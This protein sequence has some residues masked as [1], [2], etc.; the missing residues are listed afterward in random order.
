MLSYFSGCTDPA[1]LTL[2]QDVHP[3]TTDY[4]VAE[5]LDY[6]N[7]SLNIWYCRPG[8]EYGST[9]VLIDTFEVDVNGSNEI[10]EA[11]LEDLALEIATAA[12]DFFYARGATSKAPFMFDISQAGFISAGSVPMEMVFYMEEGEASDESDEYPYDGTWPYGNG[13]SIGCPSTPSGVDAADL[14]RRDLRRSI[15]YGG[16][17]GN[18]GYAYNR[19]YSICF[20]VGGDNCFSYEIP[21]N[22]PFPDEL[23]DEEDLDNQNDVT[24]GDNFYDYLIFFNTSWLSNFH[25]CLDDEEMNFYFESMEEVAEDE[26]GSG[27]VGSRYIVQVEVVY[28]E[29]FSTE[30][31]VFQSYLV[32]YANIITAI[33]TETPLPYINP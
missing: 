13:E 26:L 9:V 11:D 15:T 7:D 20:N 5:A 17:N 22:I 23:V 14:F 27:N 6:L 19:P 29:I 33:G 21:D 3:R 12:G 1:E 2:N 28:N 8:D 24:N 32:T 25:V 31:T 18:G 10:E 16:K 30:T 4:T